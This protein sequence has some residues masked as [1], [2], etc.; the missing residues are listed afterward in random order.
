MKNRVEWNVERERDTHDSANTISM[1]TATIDGITRDVVVYRV[2]RGCWELVDRST[3]E[4]LDV[5]A[6]VGDHGYREARVKCL[7]YIASLMLEIDPYAVV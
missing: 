2:G 4:V 6:G 3:G 5:C 1:H 7:D